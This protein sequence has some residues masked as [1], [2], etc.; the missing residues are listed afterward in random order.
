MHTYGGKTGVSVGG[1]V[2]EFTDQQRTRL[3]ALVYDGLDRSLSNDTNNFEKGKATNITFNWNIQ[4]DD[5]IISTVLF[6]GVDKSANLIGNQVFNGVV[7]TITKMLAITVQSGNNPA[8]ISSTAYARVPQFTGKIASGETEPVYT[9]V[10]LLAYSKV[11]QSNSTIS[12]TF[13]LA[14]EY[15]FFIVNNA[16]SIFTDLDTNF[17]LNVGDWNST[18]AFFIK[19]TVTIYLADGTTELVTLCRTRQPKTQTLNVKIN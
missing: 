9:Q 1:D 3:I 19:K 5:D 10:G 2:K 17:G 13:V 4:A 8:N 6:D 18:T 15:A 11:I 12:K 7:A 14:N 16:N